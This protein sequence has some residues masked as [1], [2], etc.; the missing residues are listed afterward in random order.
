M[1]GGQP[2]KSICLWDTNTLT[3]YRQ[4]PRHHQET[5]AES[6]DRECYADRNGSQLAAHTPYLIAEQKE[7]LTVLA[8]HLNQS[9]IIVTLRD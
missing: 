2:S 8:D 3:Q 4:T 9:H 7:V 1:F 6:S 5:L